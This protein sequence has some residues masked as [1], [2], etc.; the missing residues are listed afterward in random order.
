MTSP[1][2][3]TIA[4]EYERPRF[5]YTVSV[6]GDRRTVEANYC[7]RRDGQLA[8]VEVTDIAATGGSVGVQRTVVFECPADAAE[9]VTTER[10]CT[11]VWDVQI[12]RSPSLLERL[13]PWRWPPDTDQSPFHDIADGEQLVHP[14]ADDLSSYAGEVLHSLDAAPA[15]GTQ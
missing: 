13:L 5:E 11:D 3:V 4:Y 2:P 14:D 6:D 8:F 1:S 15:N 12:I 7:A 10:V 9:I